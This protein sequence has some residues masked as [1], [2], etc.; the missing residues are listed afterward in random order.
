MTRVLEHVAERWHHPLVRRILAVA[1]Q[2]LVSLDTLRQPAQCLSVLAW[3]VSIWGLYGAVNYVLLVAVGQRPSALAALFLLAVLQLGV[4]VP[5][6]PGRVG[7]YHYLCVQALAVFGVEGSSALSYA[8]VL[9]LISVV[10]PMALGAA[11]AWRLGVD[12][13]RPSADAEEA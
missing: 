12:K 5:S 13:W 3:S 9:H 10:V 2:L 7:V 11:L 4:A 1:S 8:I 6:S